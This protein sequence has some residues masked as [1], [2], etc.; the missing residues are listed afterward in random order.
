[1]C[2]SLN[3]VHCEFT[4]WRFAVEVSQHLSALLKLAFS[5]AH[6]GVLCCANHPAYAAMTLYRRND[7]GATQGMS[8][9][10][11]L[12]P[13]Q[14]RRNCCKTA[15]CARRRASDVIA[16]CRMHTSIAG[17]RVPCLL[18]AKFALRDVGSPTAG[19]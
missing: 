13:A 1:M 11:G 3:S 7:Y 15:R 6:I 4:I 19:R 10:E 18:G 17:S 2:N 5:A 8:D 14:L 12:L 9:E 16:A